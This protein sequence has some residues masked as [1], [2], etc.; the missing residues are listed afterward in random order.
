MAIHYQITQEM[1][2]RSFKNN[3]FCFMVDNSAHYSDSEPE[4]MEKQDTIQKIINIARQSID[5][6]FPNISPFSDFTFKKFKNSWWE[7]EEDNVWY[8]SPENL[9][10]VSIDNYLYIPL[11]QTEKCFF[12]IAFE[13]KEEFLNHVLEERLMNY[14]KEKT[15]DR[16]PSHNY[17]HMF[18]VCENS[19][20]IMDKLN[21]DFIDDI[22]K[23][24]V[25]A[26]SL[27]HDI[28]DYKYCESEEHKNKEEQNMTEE[29]KRFFSD[30]ET[31]RLM[32]IIDN[33]SFSKEKKNLINFEDF[34]KEEYLMRNIVSDADK[35]E[36]IGFIGIKR[37][38]E[39]AKNLYGVYYSDEE[40]IKDHVK[41]HYKEKLSLL[42]S[43]YIRTKPGKELAQ[44]LDREMKE[45]ID[46]N[47]HKIWNYLNCLELN[48][49][50][51]TKSGKVEWIYTEN[52]QTFIKQIKRP[53]VLTF[54][55][56]VEM[57]KYIKDDKMIDN[58]AKISL[59]KSNLQKA[60]RQNIPKVAMA[61][62]Y[63]LIKYKSGMTELLRRLCIIIIEDKFDCYKNIANHYN[64]LVW[65]MVTECVWD[66]WVNWIL[67]VISFICDKK[68]I[69]IDNTNDIDFKW[70]K[71]PYSC[72]I[73]LRM[74][75]GGMKCD[76]ILLKN[77]AKLVEKMNPNTLNYD[78]ITIHSPEIIDNGLKIIKNSVDFH[79]VPGMIK[80]IQE[81]YPD[82]TDEQIK[83]LI[84]EYSSSLRFDIPFKN[85]ENHEMWNNIEKRVVKFQKW[86]IDKMSYKIHN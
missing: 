78:N 44:P 25:Y 19:K 32:F 17:E 36:A 40:I 18:K 20:K 10:I 60:V 22:F 4:E 42:S 33:I 65:M 54:T 63:E 52:P 41:C 39:Y 1:L 76:T 53:R 59:L 46:N 71:N 38:I 24:K 73:L 82:Y 62:A 81:K 49:Y 14:C 28:V 80:F 64:L 12:Y 27:F 7:D 70:S 35:L 5:S 56:N 67:G 77:A 48:T 8:A 68:Y 85:S 66:G 37:C 75:Y 79:C 86:Y 3:M 84:W 23:R 11:Y 21:I 16:D 50:N 13:N 29:L 83:K 15:I 72:S 34:T 26:I 45:V 43:H 55:S 74:M 9:T 47:N 30:Q 69:H 31:E 51:V 61:T 58:R 6:D 57:K 2:N